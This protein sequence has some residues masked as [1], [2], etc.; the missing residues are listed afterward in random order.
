ML[1]AMLIA[2]NVGIP[3]LMLFLAKRARVR[4]AERHHSHHDTYSVPVSFTRALSYAIYL[5]GA[6]GMA[7]HYLAHTG[8][9]GVDPAAVIAF[10][11]GFLVVAFL[12]WMCVGRYKV[13]TFNDCL[14]V[15]P[16]VGNDVWVNYDKIDRLV[17]YGGT[18]DHGH[19]SLDVYVDGARKITIHGLVDIEQILMRVDRFDVLDYEGAAGGE[20]RVDASVGGANAAAGASAAVAGSGRDGLGA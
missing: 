12:C 15:T 13:S 9:L 1:D 16:L 4:I 5:M 11:D 10:F 14:V 8:V 3:V 20:G 18:E 17:R 6:L 7:L 2:I 19:R